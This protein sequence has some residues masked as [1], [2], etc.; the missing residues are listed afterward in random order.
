MIKISYPAYAFK[1]KNEDE[2]EFIFDE[3][4]KQW[5]R[6]TPEEWVRQNFLRYLMDVKK[7][8]AS[9]IAVE[10]EIKLNDLSKRFDIVVFNSSSLPW[11]LVECKNMEETLNEKTAMQVIRYNM[12]MPVS[13]FIITNGE[14]VFGFEKING[15]LKEINE[16]PDHSS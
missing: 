7:Y 16:L 8:P 5:V 11:L 3:I 2:K 1:I 6:L 9:L 14:Y 12:A 10:R 15:R 4:R 13:F